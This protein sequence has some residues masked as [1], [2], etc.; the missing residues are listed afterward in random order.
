[1]FTKKKKN[2]NHSKLTPKNKNIIKK[3][4]SQ[5]DTVSNTYLLTEIKTT[6]VSWFSD[7]LKKS[8]KRHNTQ[9]P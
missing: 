7:T 9:C 6:K 3:G 5:T 2:F 1:M 8:F 4:N